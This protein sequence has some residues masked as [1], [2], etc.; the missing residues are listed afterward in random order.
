MTL[1]PLAART[2]SA[3]TRLASSSRGWALPASTTCTGRSPAEQG[4]RPL[5]VADQQV[6]ALVGGHPAGEAR[7]SARRDR[8]AR[9]AAVDVLAQVA[10]ARRSTTLRARTN[11][12][13]SA[14]WR[15]RASHSSAG[16]DVAAPAPTP[17]GRRRAEHQSSGR[18]RSSSS[19]IGAPIQVGTWTPLVTWPIGTSSSSRSGHSQLPH[20]TRHLAVA[21][22]DAVG[23]AAHAQRRLGDAERAQ[24]SSAPWSVRARPARRPSRRAATARRPTAASISSAG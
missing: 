3:A 13:S 7:S 17:P 12:T 2:G 11:S 20:L 22:A 24:R 14:R 18:W 8:S 23:G 15:R 4:E 21:A 6:Q 1:A 19:R 9:A 10:A 16:G 5:G